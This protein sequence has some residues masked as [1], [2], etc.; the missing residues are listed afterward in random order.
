MIVKPL[1]GIAEAEAYWWLTYFKHYCEKL[2]MEFSTYDPCLLVILLESECFGVVGMQTD[3]T[4]GFGDEAF[5]TKESKELVFAAKEKQFLTP[6]NALFLMNVSLPWSVTHY[7]FARRT[8]GKSLRRLRIAQPTCK[9]TRAPN[10][11]GV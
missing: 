5:I 4:F 3:N 10:L 7:V 2:K 6:D 8:R 11:F 1:Y 9:L